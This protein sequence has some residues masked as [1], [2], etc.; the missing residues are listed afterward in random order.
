[1][2][3][4]STCIHDHFFVVT[5]DAIRCFSRFSEF[6]LIRGRG[7]DFRSEMIIPESCTRLLLVIRFKAPRSLQ[8]ASYMLVKFLFVVIKAQ[9]VMLHDSFLDCDLHHLL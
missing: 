3:A 2:K 5:N 8:K 1:M 6:L 4:S 7:I 9:Y